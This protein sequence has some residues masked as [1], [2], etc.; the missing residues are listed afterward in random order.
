LAVALRFVE[1]SACHHDVA[2]R[3][4]I[5][6]HELRE[7]QRRADVQARG[8]ALGLVEVEPWIGS[9]AAAR[10]AGFVVLAPL[11]LDGAMEVSRA[12]LPPLAWYAPGCC[13]ARERSDRSHAHE[14]A[15]CS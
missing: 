11:D 14:K 12:L 9:A 13:R 10:D 8:S 2:Q 1:L 6:G 4:V 15:P 5:L 7:S 3:A